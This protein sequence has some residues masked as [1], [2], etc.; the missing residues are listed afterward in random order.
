MPT[1]KTPSP[2]GT[3]YALPTG[4]GFDLAPCP[5]PNPDSVFSALVAPVLEQ[6]GET[7]DARRA[8]E[9]NADLSSLGRDKQLEPVRQRLVAGITHVWSS[10]ASIEA[11]VDKREAALLAVPTV[12]P[13]HS[14]VA[15]EDA[16]IRRWWGAQPGKARAKLLERIDTEPGHERLMIALM[17]SPVP[18]GLDYEITAVRATWNRTR[19]LDNPAAAVAIDTDRAALEWARRALSTAAGI[20]PAVTGWD[21]PRILRTIVESGGTKGH[22]AFGFTPLDHAAMQQRIDADKRGLA[23]QTGT[24]AARLG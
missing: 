21:R 11:G 15:V 10:L 24:A 2:D 22:E 1:T 14:A 5:D 23:M 20:A 7:V 12:D 4:H 16:E 6:L 13:A 19:R 9:A 17:R 8:I 3:H 18:V